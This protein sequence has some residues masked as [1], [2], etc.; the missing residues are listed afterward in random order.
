MF[1]EFFSLLSTHWKRPWCWERLRAGK[2]GDR[3]WDGWMAS[4]TRWTWVWTSSRSWWWTGRPWRSWGHKEWDTTER[5]NN[6]RFK[7]RASKWRKISSM[8]HFLESYLKHWHK[9]HANGFKDDP[10]RAWIFCDSL[11]KLQKTLLFTILYKPKSDIIH[12]RVH[13]KH[14][15]NVWH[16]SIPKTMI[17]L[18]MHCY[19]IIYI[20][21]SISIIYII[22]IYYIK[23]YTNISSNM[24]TYYNILVYNLFQF[25]IF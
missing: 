10:L 15:Q 25:I 5:L 8:A 4:P 6:N 11:Q 23:H 14:I 18:H 21:P 17:M 16:H 1:Q 19:T 2:G 12:A 13:T 9:W 3:G 24:S 7:E 22:N 20:A